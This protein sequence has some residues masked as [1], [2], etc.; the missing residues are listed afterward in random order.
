MS[1]TLT[2]PPAPPR[3]PTVEVGPLT[4]AN[5]VRSEWIKLRSLRSTVNVS[6]LTVVFMV[7]LGL[8]V[9]Y[10][11]HNRW[12]NLGPDEQ[13]PANVIRRSLVGVDIAQL[14][15]GVLGVLVITGEYTTGMIRATLGAV[16]RRLP[17]LWGKIAVFAPVTF[18]LTLAAAFAAFL[19]GQA[20]LGPHGLSLDA[21]GAL[22]AV[23]GVALYLT[24]LGVLALA[25]GFIVRNTA[26]AITSVFAVI[27]VLP[28]LAAALPNSWQSTIVPYLPSS[29]G[30]AVY[31]THSTPNSLHPWPGFALFCAYTAL[32]VAVAG[33]ALCRRDA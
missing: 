10:F 4:Q 15:V 25:F 31:M 22:R 18:V 9:S 23:F 7:G 24:V 11:T 21:P 14:S 8:L 28:V 29:A 16:P 1:A 32:A 20:I 12:N 19:G 5:V 3:R 2:L 6:A 13:S 30:Q 17:V 33:F 26:G 27:L